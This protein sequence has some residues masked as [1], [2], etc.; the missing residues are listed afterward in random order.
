MSP[1]SALERGSPVPRGWQVSCPSASSGTLQ[2]A[3][4]P[5]LLPL[6]SHLSG[7]MPCLPDKLWLHVH[8]LRSLPFPLRMLPL[9][10]NQNGYHPVVLFY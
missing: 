1:S 2:S 8:V 7:D 5:A 3:V 6:R 10:Y 9:N 4:V